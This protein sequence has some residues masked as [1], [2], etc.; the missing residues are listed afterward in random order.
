MLFHTI[1]ACSVKNVN[2]LVTFRKAIY[3]SGTKQRVKKV[4][5]AIET[6]TFS[7]ISKKKKKQISCLVWW[8]DCSYFLPVA[9]SPPWGQALLMAVVYVC[10]AP[11]TL[12]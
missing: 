12:H 6:L 5:E 7:R 3:L 2:M 11:A 4:N 10:L 1:K 8:C 9:K